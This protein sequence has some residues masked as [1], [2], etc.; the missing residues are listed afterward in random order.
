MENQ[1]CYY[2]EEDESLWLAISRQDESGL[3]WTELIKVSE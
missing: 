3:T 1:G 2:L